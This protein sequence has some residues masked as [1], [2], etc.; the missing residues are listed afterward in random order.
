KRD[1][2]DTLDPQV[3]IEAYP[4]VKDYAPFNTASGHANYVLFD[5]A[6]GLNQFSFVTDAYASSY[7][8]R[9]DVDVA[10]SQ[11]FR[12]LADGVTWDEIFTGTSEV[13][14][15]GIFAYD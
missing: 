12:R 6:A 7:Y 9:F 10:Y 1:W 8:V 11:N 13:P 3:V 4:L 2:S 5:P 15:P 14:A